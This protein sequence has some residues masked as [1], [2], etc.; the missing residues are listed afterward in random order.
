MLVPLGLS[1]LGVFAKRL[2]FFEFAQSINDAF[3]LSHVTAMWGP[4]IS[5]NPFLAPVDPN[6]VS[7]TPHR[8]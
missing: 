3:S 2:L 8:I 7:T 1:S 5:S 6:P 4:P